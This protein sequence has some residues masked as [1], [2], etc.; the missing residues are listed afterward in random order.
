MWLKEEND[1][2]TEGIEI[3]KDM[4]RQKDGLDLGSL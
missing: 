3:L 2:L 4:L 1:R